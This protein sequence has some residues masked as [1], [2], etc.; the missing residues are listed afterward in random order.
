[1]LTEIENTSYGYIVSAF[2]RDENGHGHW[3]RLR[4]FGERQGDAIEFR[5]ID[6][7]TFTDLRLRGFIKTFRITDKYKRLSI[8]RYAKV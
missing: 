8:G 4:N 3:Y 2:M 6:L 7:P 1:M 5:D